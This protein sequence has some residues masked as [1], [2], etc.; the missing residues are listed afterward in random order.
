M[1]KLLLAI[2]LMVAL[3]VLVQAS[4]VANAPERPDPASADSIIRDFKLVGARLRAEGWRHIIP[5]G[6]S[7]SQLG[8]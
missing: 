3:A 2:N 8:V 4:R 7:R 1:V 6:L 5:I